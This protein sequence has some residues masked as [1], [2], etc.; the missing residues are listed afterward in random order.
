MHFLGIHIAGF[1]VL[2]LFLIFLFEK[3][4]VSGFKDA[5]FLLTNL[6]LFAKN[7]YPAMITF[8]FLA[9]CYVNGRNLSFSAPPR[10]YAE[11]EKYISKNGIIISPEISKMIGYCGLGNISKCRCSL[12]ELSKL[13]IP[14][15][16]K[17]DFESIISKETKAQN[18]SDK[19]LR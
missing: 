14:Q 6:K 10:V 8:V 15:S 3:K 16:I 5:G 18:K 17:N 11:L 19:F 12:A 9:F 7:F 1:G 13:D 4:R 2:F